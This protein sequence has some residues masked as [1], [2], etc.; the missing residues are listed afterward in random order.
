MDGIQIEP[1][2]GTTGA[3]VMEALQEHAGKRLYF[4][5][6]GGNHGDRLILE[7]ARLCIERV[8]FE[9]VDDPAKAEL[10]LINGGGGAFVQP[11]C[12][13]LH[14]VRRY[15]QGCPHTP[16]I[17]LPSSYWWGDNE[18]SSLFSG[19]TAPATL[20]ARERLSHQRL[21]QAN[22]PEMV[23]VGLDHDMAFHLADSPL[24]RQAKKVDSKGY[25][26]IVERFDK[27]NLDG[28]QPALGRFY[29]Y[30]RWLPRRLQKLAKWTLERT[31][32][33]NSTFRRGALDE[34]VKLLP[35][36]AGKPTIYQDVSNVH[37]N[38]FQEFVD[39][40]AAA[41]AVITTRMHAGILAAMLG[42]A[43][44]FQPRDNEYQKLQSVYA[45]SLANNPEVFLLPEGL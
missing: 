7:G 9:V 19:R 16:A 36:L 32:S 5:P 35:R 29:R 3:T 4:E 37:R 22:L 13:G 39:M 25:L 44:F 1:C 27:E 17:V 11:W 18:L 15:F 31:R 45:F 12:E 14:L 23:A 20:F 30:G 33:A 38:S 24:M 21:M 40:I 10:I 6:L 26:L 43:A 41:E 8:G 2:A 42:K 28:K 34:A